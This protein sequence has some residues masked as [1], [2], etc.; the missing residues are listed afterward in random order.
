MEK[1]RRKEER[2]EERREEKRRFREDGWSKI[3]FTVDGMDSPKSPLLLP[4]QSSSSPTMHNC[5]F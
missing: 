5:S 1:K 2:R 3:L 4:C